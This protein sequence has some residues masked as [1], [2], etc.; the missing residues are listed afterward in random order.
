M[1]EPTDEQLRD[2]AAKLPQIY[3]DILAAFP[4]A[5]PQRRRGDALQLE[6]ILG[7]LPSSEFDTGR[8][9]RRD[10]EDA[11]ENLRD[12]EI[13]NDNGFTGFYPTD[14][15]ERLIGVLTGHPAPVVVVPPL[16]ALTW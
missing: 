2:Y 14:L 5:D 13:L 8:P 12:A 11:I 3:K 6:R 1:P 4:V 15:G 7:G 10:V 16:P 9:P